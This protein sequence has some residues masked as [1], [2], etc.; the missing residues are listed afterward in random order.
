MKRRPSPAQR[1]KD[2][3]SRTFQ[4][5][6]LTDGLTSPA[7][8]ISAAYRAI[9]ELSAI[10]DDVASGRLQPRRRRLIIDSAIRAARS[11]LWIGRRSSPLP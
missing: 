4:W 1:R 9:A 8:H 3:I 2:A 7:A 11:N 5:W 10:R 6:Y